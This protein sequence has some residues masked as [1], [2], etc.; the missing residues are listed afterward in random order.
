M[1]ATPKKGDRFEKGDS[2]AKGATTEK[3]GRG[4]TSQEKRHQT[5]HDA[6]SRDTSPETRHDDASRGHVT[7]MRAR[8]VR[9]GTVR[10]GKCKQGRRD[11]LN[12]EQADERWVEKGARAKSMNDLGTKR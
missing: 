12:S 3:G 8:T 7:R 10:A 11:S 9:A 4:A 5:R 1:G 2:A 6:T